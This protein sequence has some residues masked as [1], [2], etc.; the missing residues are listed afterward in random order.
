MYCIF[1]EIFVAYC[2]CGKVL[3]DTAECKIGQIFL[4]MLGNFPIF[5]SYISFFCQDKS[6]RRGVFYIRYENPRGVHKE[7]LGSTKRNTRSFILSHFFIVNYFN[8]QYIILISNILLLQEF[9][10]MIYKLILYL[11]WRLILNNIFSDGEDITTSLEALKFRKITFNV[12]LR[13][14]NLCFHRII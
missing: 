11:Y 9:F 1:W 2:I 3:F 14:I 12:L 6:H 4:K 5:Y 8:K 7:I 10:Y 13:W